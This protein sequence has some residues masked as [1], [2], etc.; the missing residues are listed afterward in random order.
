MIGEFNL[1]G[2]YFPWL[3]VLGVITLG[4]S[5]VV[6][7]AMARAGLY[8]LVWHPALFDLALYLVLLYGMT[9]ISPYVFQR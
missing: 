2:I 8:R 1:Y 7:R 9:L 4:V 5:W 6:R 3:L